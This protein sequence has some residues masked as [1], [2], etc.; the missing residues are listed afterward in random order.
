MYHTFLIKIM[1]LLEICLKVNLYFSTWS[2]FRWFTYGWIYTRISNMWILQSPKFRSQLSEHNDA[3]FDDGV[4][5]EV[6][7]DFDCQHIS[8]TEGGLTWLGAL[9]CYVL[10]YQAV[11]FSDPE[12]KNPA[13]NRK[14]NMV[15]EN[16]RTG[17][18]VLS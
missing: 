9:T 14:M 6:A 15:I 3:I 5:P 18:P 13:V 1:I 12:S 10:L 16:P 7:L 2:T 4:A 8:K 11:K 17:P